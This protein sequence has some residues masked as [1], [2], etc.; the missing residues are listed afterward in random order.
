MTCWA[1]LGYNTRL[2]EPPFIPRT[3]LLLHRTQKRAASGKPVRT[4]LY[5]TKS[6][7]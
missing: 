4:L 5:L 3:S 6:F 7:N 2:F 1:A